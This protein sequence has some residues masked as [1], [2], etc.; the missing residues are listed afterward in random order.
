MI[1]VMICCVVSF[2]VV[3]CSS[4]VVLYVRAFVRCVAV[5]AHNHPVTSTRLCVCLLSCVLSCMLAYFQQ[6]LYLLVC[7]G[8]VCKLE[9][10]VCCVHVLTCTRTDHRTKSCV[11]V[12]CVCVAPPGASDVRMSTGERICVCLSVS[13]CMCVCACCVFSNQFLTP[14]PMRTVCQYVCQCAYV[15]VFNMRFIVCVHCVTQIPNR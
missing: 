11:C 7:P 9:H 15:C 3:L 10:R 6:P 14:N 12:S 8:H 2:L 13:M 4:C 1:C 5:H